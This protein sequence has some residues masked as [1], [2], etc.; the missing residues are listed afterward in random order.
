M[1][2][3]WKS[4]DPWRELRAVQNEVD[5]LLGGFFPGL[6]TSGPPHASPP[7]DV[8]DA[9]EAYVVSAVVPGLTQEELSIE[10]TADSVTIAA[11]RA[12]KAPEGYEA[13]RAE[14]PTIKMNRTVRFKR[15]IDVDSIEAS[16]KDG[17]LTVRLTKQ[18]KDRPRSIAIKAA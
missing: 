17:L 8:V 6:V 11:E 10:A 9:G 7:F 3:Q 14:R 5:S 16:L 15:R 1:L 18:A 4:Y 2:T 12:P 13:L